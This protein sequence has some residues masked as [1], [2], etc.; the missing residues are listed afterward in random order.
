MPKTAAAGDTL[1]REK[2]YDKLFGVYIDDS[3]AAERAV[4]IVATGSM[5]ST[6]DTIPVRDSDGTILGYLAVYANVDLT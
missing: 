1:S 2:V 4:A 6:T 5:P 3:I